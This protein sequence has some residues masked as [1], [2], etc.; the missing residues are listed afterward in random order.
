MK[1]TILK[2][3]NNKSYY[4]LEELDYNNKKYAFAS[5]CDLGKETLN[6]NEFVIMEVKLI[7]DELVVDEIYD[8]KVAEEV[9][10]LFKKKFQEQ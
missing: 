7:N 2:L 8:D 1:D 3:A 5:E 9:T 6:E 4:I 10:L